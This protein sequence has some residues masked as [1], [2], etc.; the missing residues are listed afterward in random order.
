MGG[1][2]TEMGSNL[3]LAFTRDPHIVLNV[4]YLNY[5]NLILI[6]TL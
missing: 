5:P 2:M 1:V 4:L 6:P 3:Y